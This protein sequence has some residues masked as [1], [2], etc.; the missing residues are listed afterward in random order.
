MTVLKT[1]RDLDV[2][3]LSMDFVIQ[4]YMVTGTFPSHEKFGLV[5]QLRRAGVSICS[6]IA[7]GAARH[8]PKE[9]VQFLYIALGSVSEIETQLEIAFRLGYLHSIDTE[10]EVLNRLRRM[11]VCLIRAVGMKLNKGILD[12]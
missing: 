2:W 12:G 9:Y 1:H 8:Y 11:L 7:E 6:N 3:K 10:K 5:A 4:I